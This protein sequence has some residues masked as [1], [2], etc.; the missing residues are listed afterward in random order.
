MRRKSI[1]TFRRRK[2]RAQKSNRNPWLSKR[3][4]RRPFPHLAEPYAPDLVS[5]AQTNVTVIILVVLL[6]VWKSSSKEHAVRASKIG[7][8]GE[9]ALRRKSIDEMQV[10]QGRR[11]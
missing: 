10:E 3:K 5:N 8:K 9:G 1:S 11:K 7:T 2:L 4:P 6:L